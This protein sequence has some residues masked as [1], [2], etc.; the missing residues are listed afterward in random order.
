MLTFFVKIWM[1]YVSYVMT[2][3]FHIYKVFAWPQTHTEEGL[4]GKRH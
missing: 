3:T 1:S 2:S 4:D